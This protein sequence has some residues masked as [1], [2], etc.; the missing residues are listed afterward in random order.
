MRIARIQIKNFRNFQSIDVLLRQNAVILGENKIG[1]SNLLFAL[2]LVLDASLPDS[3]RQL[4]EEDF[5][6]QLPRDGTESIEISVDLTDFSEDENQLA[7][8]ADHLVQTD[9]MIARLTY[10]F[11][12]VSQVG[13]EVKYEFTIYGG[14]RP[15]NHLGPEVRRRLPLDVLPALRDAEGDLANWRRSPLR[16]LLDA[17]ATNIQADELTE[18]AQNISEEQQRISDLEPIKMLCESITSRLETMM[19]PQQA[20]DFSLGFSP[21]DP[22]RLVRFLRPFIDNGLRSISEASLGSANLIYLA[23][24]ILEIEYLV[25]QGNRDH[26][27][28]A[29]EEPEAHLHPHLQRL[30]FGD[31]FRSDSQPGTR[32]ILVTT[33]SPNIASVSPIDSFVVL[34]KSP[35]RKST[36]AVSTASLELDRPDIDDLQRYLDVTR[37]EIVFAR[38]V[39]LVEGDGERF[40]VPKLASLLG[41]NLD[42]LGISVC[43]VSGTNFLPYVKFLGRAGLDLPLA[44]LTDFDPNGE[45]GL[46]LGR[47]RKLLDATSEGGPVDVED[48]ELLEFAEQSGFFVGE[49]TLEVDLFRQGRHKSVCNTIIALSSNSRARQRAQAWLQDPN[50]LN[51]GQFLSDID[52]ISKGR[53][54][55]R[56][57]SRISGTA[58]PAYISKAIGY[59]AQRLE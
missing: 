39:L 27:F 56:L 20:V 58:C 38:G 41:Y 28:L 57:A 14:G 36:I 21:T 5:W 50:S 37:A 10:A 12:P 13:D 26:T 43:S 42:A 32:T 29:I 31:F 25:A 40:L 15:E 23:L 17:A 45:S 47:V 49:Y 59:L 19:G 48:G 44:A 33:H 9:P 18:I 4:R 34:K 7:I 53:F 11:E 35:D 6:D 1:K 22:A 46:A 16:L 54:A 24:R 2:R 51:E 3:V 30:T 8:L 52:E 55:Q